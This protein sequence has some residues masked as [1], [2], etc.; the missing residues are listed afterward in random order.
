MTPTSR[1]YA[2]I[3]AGGSGQ[4]FWP[5]SRDRLPK[6]LLRLFDDKSMLEHTVARLEGLVPRENI[7]ILTNHLQLDGVRAAL[8]NFPLENIVAEPEKRDTAPA[9]ALAIGWVAARDP[10]ATM[11]VLP[12]DH[13][14]QDTA[15]FQRALQTACS[16][17]QESRALVTI[18]IKPTWPCPSYGYVER[19][20]RFAL[21]QDTGVPVFDVVRFREKPN[22]E[23][24][25][26]FLAQGNFTWNAGMFFWTL[27]SV[28]E[29]LAQHCAELSAFVDALAASEDFAAT[30]HTQF[31]TLPKL[32]IDYA[33]ME[34]APRVLNVEACFD[35][36]DVGN[37][38]SVGSY[39]AKDEHG[40]QHNC[41]LSQLDADGNL[42]YSQTGQHVALLGVSDLMVIS[43]GDALLVAHRSQAE[44]LK[45]LVDGLP[46]EL[47]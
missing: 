22:A 36:D 16:A 2:L 11:M 30:V 21:Q 47:R 13:L 17:A 27:P 38:T 29:N 24:A 31:P 37:W 40:N 5:A 15:Q 34:K 45:K 8:P 43:T 26:Q 18:G 25:E 32:S 3:L 28:R 12:S 6:Q 7:L 19:G 23:L 46:K 35:W 42:V 9:I 14:I 33:L 10:E 20:A 39:L 4:R 44:K 1:T 41:A